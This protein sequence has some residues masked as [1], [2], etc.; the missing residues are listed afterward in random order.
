LSVKALDSKLFVVRA[1][2]GP[3]APRD[4]RLGVPAMRGFESIEFRKPVTFFAGENGSGKSTIIE[5][6]AV[7]AGFNEEGGS[8]NFRF[9][10]VRREEESDRPLFFHLTRSPRFPS[11][12]YFLRAESFFN[13]ATEI[14][15]L[16]VT[17]GYGGVSLHEQSHGESF[18][19]LLMNRFLGDGLYILD[20]PEAALSPARQLALLARIHQLIQ[21]GSQFLI[22]THS[23]IVMAYPNATI[24]Q[25]DDGMREVAYEETD[26][27]LVTRDFLNHRKKML[28]EL[29]S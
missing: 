14:D 13:V 6:L 9:E 3:S 27:Y 12:G 23:P 4:Y 17:R 29:L 2:L 18:L 1:E 20:E 24:L 25:L 5:A 11:D 7:A 19:A 10:T 22:A 28:D 16:G 26:H 21:R 15:R 8:K